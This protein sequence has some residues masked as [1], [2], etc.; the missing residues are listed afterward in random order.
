M[1]AAAEELERLYAAEQAKPPGERQPRVEFDYAAQAALAED[2]CASR[3]RI[4]PT[5]PPRLTPR[6][7]RGKSDEG[8][9]ILEGDARSPAPARPHPDAPGAQISSSGR[10]PSS[11]RAACT[12]SPGRTAAEGCA[13]SSALHRRTAAAH[14]GWAQELKNARRYLELGVER[15]P[16]SERVAEELR[17]LRSQVRQGLAARPPRT[18]P[19]SPSPAALVLFASARF[20]S[21]RVRVSACAIES[22]FRGSA[23]NRRRRRGGSVV[24]AGRGGTFPASVLAAVTWSWRRRLVRCL[25]KCCNT[26]HSMLF[27]YTRRHRP[28]ESTTSSPIDASSDAL[29]GSLATARLFAPCDGVCSRARGLFGCGEIGGLCLYA[30]SPSVLRAPIP[31]VSASAPSSDE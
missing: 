25:A 1:V 12:T 26:I 30:P 15:H 4:A 6:R 13:P 27:K 22:P 16:S 28:G 8:I 24:W 10:W 18:H 21:A 9:R 31:G 2:A 17:E 23:L 5:H 20:F 3:P 7:R 29:P 14:P 19:P 11:R